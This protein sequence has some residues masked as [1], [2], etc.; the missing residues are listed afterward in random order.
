ML[1]IREYS[2]FPLSLF[3]SLILMLLNSRNCKANCSSLNVR[4]DIMWFYAS[5]ENFEEH[6]LIKT[7]I[8]ELQRIKGRNFSLQ[9]KLLWFPL[10]ENQWHHFL[11][12]KGSW[13]T[14]QSTVLFLAICE[15]Y[16]VL[17]K[18]YLL[19]FVE[20]KKERYINVL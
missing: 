10:T 20:R 15:V 5:N 17:R 13:C 1:G 8:I 6:S 19:L 3:L 16:G 11:I 14:S 2:S 18:K 7:D 12:S 9:N 4:W